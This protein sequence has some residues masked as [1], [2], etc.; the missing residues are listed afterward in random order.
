MCF[1]GLIFT[2]NTHII[3]VREGDWAL[4]LAME[5]QKCTI[6]VGR[7]SCHKM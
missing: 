2:I 6:C 1:I 7:R 4:H 3:V 5:D